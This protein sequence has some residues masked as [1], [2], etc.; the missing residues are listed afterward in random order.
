VNALQL[1]TRHLYF[2]VDALQLQIAAG[3][4]LMRLHGRPP[5]R[6]TVGIDTLAQDF[7]LGERESLSMVDQML[8]YG[9]LERGQPNPNQFAVTDK[10]RQYAQARIV[11]PMPR[12]R[13]QLMISH[14]AD[15]AAHFN[16]TASNNK[17]EIE[18]LA[19]YGGYMSREPELPDLSVGIT[20]RRRSLNSRPLV[21]RA[22][23]PN[24]GPEQIRELFEEL[25]SFVRVTFFHRLQNVPRPFTVIFKDEG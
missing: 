4:V 14:M 7:R 20:G 8:Q 22:T 2:G 11:E 16:R 24:G 10:F 19:V 9:L 6:A 21:G 3:R 12:T 25:S 18:A 13:A 17:Y 23:A 15:L 1:V 5:D